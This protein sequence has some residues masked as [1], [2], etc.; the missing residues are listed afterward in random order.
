MVEDEAFIHSLPSEVLEYIIG[1]V[2]PYNDLQS[3]KLVCKKWLEVVQGMQ[4][5]L[6]FAAMTPDKV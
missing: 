3:C 1:L 5:Y 2:S 6:W 4:Y